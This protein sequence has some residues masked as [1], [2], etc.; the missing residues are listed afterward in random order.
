MDLKIQHTG[1]LHIGMRFSGYPEEIKA[2]LISARL[3]TLDK[4]VKMANE[5]E[6]DILV[7]AGDLF[8]SI[9]VGKKHISDTI[10][11]LNKFSSLVIIIPGNHDFDSGGVEIWED[12]MKDAKD[13]ILLLN[14]ERPYSLIDHG[15]KVVF[16]PA[17]CKSKHSEKNNLGWIKE[18][19]EFEEGYYHIGLA[20]GAIE[21]LSADLEGNYYFMTMKELEAIPVDLWLIG[22]THVSYPEND[23]VRNHK[24]FNAGIHEPNG[25]H[26]RFDGYTW[27]LEIKDG[28]SYAEKIKTGKYRFHDKNFKINN[29]EDF[30]DIKAWILDNHPETMV[31]RINLAG[32]L[33]KEEYDNINRYYRE[34]ETMVFYLLVKDD[35]LKRKIDKEFIDKEFV[36]GSFPNEFLSRLV[37]D[38]NA[39]QLAYELIRRD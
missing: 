16:Y 2:K 17:P 19:N 38:E 21:G 6:A 12:F 26:H 10:K 29:E 5:K 14:E 11:A 15:F 36:K 7:V 37:D 28:N 4:I 23:K 1:D 27:F 20:H 18:F 25:L 35:D 34:L 8:E 22:H 13:N 3:E 39:L 31:L 30:Q 33:N 24:I 32:S 9:T